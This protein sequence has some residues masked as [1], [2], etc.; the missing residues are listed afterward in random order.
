MQVGPEPQELS[1]ELAMPWHIMQPRATVAHSLATSRF[2]TVSD[3]T[4]DH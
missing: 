1:D 2:S 3:E 4:M